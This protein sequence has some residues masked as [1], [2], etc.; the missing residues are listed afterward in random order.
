MSDA[1][2]LPNL[3]RW[4]KSA[5]LA[6]KINKAKQPLTWL[7]WA[8]LIAG[9][10]AVMSQHYLLGFPLLILSFVI[11]YF[12]DKHRR[13]AK[14]FQTLLDK[15]L[16]DLVLPRLINDRFQKGDLLLPAEASATLDRCAKMV[17]EIQSNY[18]EGNLT[19]RS[20]P[21][22]LRQVQK[23]LAL[24]VDV[25]MKAALKTLRRPLLTKV[26]PSPD[27]MADLASVE[28]NIR[29]FYVEADE[30]R[31]L[32]KSPVL[33]AS[34]QEVVDRVKASIELRQGL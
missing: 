11:Q 4:V 33:D 22:Q 29:T 12:G 23:E 5:L 19:N 25:L 6:E 24:R 27:E 3:Q 2:P 32:A 15:E 16:G 26:A 13:G 14:N 20:A 21:P 10:V 18:V 30:I 17:M 7:W 1:Q 28:A 8:I 9:G 34:A 31:L